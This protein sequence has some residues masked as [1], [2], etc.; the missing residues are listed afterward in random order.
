MKAV[1]VSHPSAV[2][3]SAGRG[4]IAFEETGRR[5]SKLKTGPLPFSFTGAGGVWRSISAKKH[6]FLSP[7]PQRWLAQVYIVKETMCLHPERVGWIQ[8]N[9]SIHILLVGL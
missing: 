6:E 7:T 9:V 4:L 2:A 3:Q 5:A 1:D 8:V